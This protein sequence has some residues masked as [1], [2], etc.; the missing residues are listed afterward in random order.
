[1]IYGH[2][3]RIVTIDPPGSFFFYGI[4]LLINACFGRYLPMNRSWDA[5]PLSK[6]WQVSPN[7]NSSLLRS[8]DEVP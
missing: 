2:I 5:P 7:G 3:L 8:V 4:I 6:F 1:M